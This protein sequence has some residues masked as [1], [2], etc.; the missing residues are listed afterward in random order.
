[1]WE[2]V[3]AL[4]RVLGDSAR[5]MRLELR[6]AEMWT[7]VGGL[8]VRLG[9]PMGLEAKGRALLVILAENLPEGTVIDLT[10]P[11]RPA[12]VPP[13]EEPDDGTPEP[14]VEGS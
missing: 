14:E 12:V 5:S 7:T 1:M 9:Q 8:P 10:S 6:G 4:A 2:E 13:K 3:V 11:Q